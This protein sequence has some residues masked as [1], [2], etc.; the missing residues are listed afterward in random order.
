MF[1]VFKFSKHVDLYK[2]DFALLALG[3][4]WIVLVVATYRSYLTTLKSAIARRIIG[5]DDLRVHD[6]ASRKIMKEKLASPYAEEVIYAFEALTKNDPKFL[7]DSLPDMLAHSATEVRKYALSRIDNIS[8]IIQPGLLLNLARSDSSPEVRELATLQFCS[9]YEDETEEHY[10]LFL[11]NADLKLQYAAMKGLMESGNLEAVML[12]G[13]RLNS[14][15]QAG[16]PDDNVVIARLIGEMRFKNYYK[17]LLN[18]MNGDDLRVKKA[19]IAAAGKLTHPKLIDPLFKLLGDNKLK[20]EAIRAL[21]QYKDLM[22]EHIVEHNALIKKYPAE[23]VKIC[24]LVGND[25]ATTFLAKYILPGAEAELLDECLWALYNNTVDHAHFDRNLIGAKIDQQTDFIYLCVQCQLS[26][27]VL[28]PDVAEALSTEIKNVRHRILLLLALQYNKNTFR[29]I[30]D[31]IEKGVKH[32]N[33]NALEMLDNILDTGHKQ[34]LL[35]LFESKSYS[36]TKDILSRYCT[37]KIIANHKIADTILSAENRNSFLLWTEGL[38]LYNYFENIAP[39]TIQHFQKSD[40]NL[41]REIALWI[42]RDKQISGDTGHEINNT[43]VMINKTHHI[44]RTL[45]E[46]EKIL[47]LKSVPMFTDTPERILSGLSEIMKEQSVRAGD[48]IFREGELGD[49]L[50]I[51][52]D[53]QISIHNATQEYARMGSREI[54]GELALLDPEPRSASA[55]AIKDTLLVRIDKED[56]DDLIDTQPEVTHG[57]LSILSKR[58]RSQ[59]KLINELKNSAAR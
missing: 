59:N 40:H 35:P 6:E 16:S 47:L 19:A 15:L 9:H 1:L 8:G 3:I 11:N 4:L 43:K 12:A 13:Q 34:K 33:A 55:T 20:K 24:A 38:V 10:Q 2:A 14:I 17:P 57:I 26:E 7:H 30:I 29:N 18:F 45:M 58:I 22:L 28:H 41:I 31:T 53:G 5:N 42:N 25:N 51:I 39:A 49:C 27:H 56:F 44:G 52:F 54:F 32:K 46:I 23:I 37:G 50:Y 48:I 21:S 36:E